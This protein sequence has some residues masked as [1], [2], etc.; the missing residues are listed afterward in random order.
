MYTAGGWVAFSSEDPELGAYLGHDGS[1][2]LNYASGVVLPRLDTAIF[3]FT[4]VAAP[5]P[6]TSDAQ[7]GVSTALSRALD[8]DLA[9][10]PV[11][12]NGTAISDGSGVTSNGDG[13][14]G[15]GTDSLGPGT[16]LMVIVLMLVFHLIL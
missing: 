13:P 9:D 4:N 11:I 1:N 15:N 14:A 16:P 5:D 8:G 2:T 7:K 12:E 6:A 3:G 10:L